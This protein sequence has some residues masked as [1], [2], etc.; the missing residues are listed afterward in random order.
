MKRYLTLILLL[1]LSV[2]GVTAQSAD[3]KP[4][5]TEKAEAV[6]AL[7]VE[8]LGGNRY[9]G[10]TTQIGRGKFSVIREGSVVSFQTFLDIIVFPDRER[11]EFR[12]N[13]NRIVQVNTG[14]T[15]WIFNAELE[16]LRDQNETQVEAFK[17]GI[18]TSLDNLLRG[19]WKGSAVLSYVGRRPATLGK[20][21]EVIK[22]KYNDDFEIEFEFSADDGLPQKSIHKR[23]SADGEPIIEE[24]RYAQ[25]IEVNG[26]RSPFIIDRF[27]GGKQ[28]S[29]INYESIDFNKRIPDT[30]FT[31]PANIKEAKKE[32]KL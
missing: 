11:T 21:N 14:D 24:D 22:L 7:A 15:G 29:R 2:V 16:T 32:I 28:S 8:K 4:P 20:R 13:G 25:F 6:I 10:V 23:E 26:I 12:G 19:G 30:I 27:T 9:L 17:R 31:K 18:R 1:T 3:P 5:Q